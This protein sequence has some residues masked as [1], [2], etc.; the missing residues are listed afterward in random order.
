[1]SDQPP[2][3]N[4]GKIHSYF[5]HMTALNY[6]ETPVDIITFLRS[7][8]FIGLSTNNGKAIYPGWYD[9]IQ[10]IFYNDNKY[11]VVLTGSIGIGKSTIAIYCM[12]YILYKVF[13][14]RDPHLY[15]KLAGTDTFAVS[16]FNLT[17]SL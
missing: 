13:C 4:I 5:D 11:L 2:K 6:K 7:E 8:H 14:L 1:M 12:A 15:F 17:K 10:E 16:F 9:P 3:R